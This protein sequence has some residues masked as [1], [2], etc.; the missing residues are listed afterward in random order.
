[1]SCDLKCACKYIWRASCSNVEEVWLWVRGVLLKANLVGAATLLS[2]C[3]LCNQRQSFRRSMERILN[4]VCRIRIMKPNPF[5]FFITYDL[6]LHFCQNA[7]K[8][9]YGL[10]FI[11]EKL[12]VKYMSFQ[13]PISNNHIISPFHVF[14]MNSILW[15]FEQHI[16][17]QRLATWH[18][19]S[20][21][22]NMDYEA[23][24]IAI[25]SF[26]S[27]HIACGWARQVADELR[28][29]E[30]TFVF[31]QEHLRRT[32]LS[33]NFLCC[34]MLLMRFNQTRFLGMFCRRLFYIFYDC[35]SELLCV[36]WVCWTYQTIGIRNT[37]PRCPEGIRPIFLFLYRYFPASN[38]C[39]HC[40]TL[41]AQLESL[42][43]N[44]IIYW[45]IPDSNT[46][47][48]F[49]SVRCMTLWWQ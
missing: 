8:L 7:T 44:H 32:M 45:P 24:H 29:C 18:L 46:F 39:S 42:S 21:W 33:I 9:E 5:K 4:G 17:S 28:R 48:R 38:F 34:G 47:L 20:N 37:S 3:Q 16:S 14:L 13:D 2:M 31:Q 35:P 15:I 49:I 23:G 19:P 6:R 41:R 40:Q 43:A 26:Y 22:T 12:C 10:T 30:Q 27:K 36:F 11:Y 25:F 1:M